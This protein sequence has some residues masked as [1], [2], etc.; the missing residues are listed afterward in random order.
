MIFY[1]FRWDSDDAI[2]S[3][4]F[5]LSHIFFHRE[6][7]IHP[8]HRRFQL[9]RANGALAINPS[10]QAG[11]TAERSWVRRE[12]EDRGR[13][14]TRDIFVGAGNKKICAAAALTDEGTRL[15]QVQLY[16][17]AASNARRFGP[18]PVWH[19]TLDVQHRAED[20]TLLL[21]FFKSMLLSQHK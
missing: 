19:Q 12:T 4:H 20:E 3:N 8:S 18:R 6:S 14:R 5:R 1:S 2:F 17:S 7:T 10:S 9:P 13:K 21:F 11:S 15:C 16:P